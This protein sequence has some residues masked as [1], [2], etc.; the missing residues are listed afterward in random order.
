MVPKWLWDSFRTVVYTCQ[1]IQN[2]VNNRLVGDIMP[3]K[4]MYYFVGA[5]Q[6]RDV[7]NAFLGHLKQLCT[8]RPQDKVLD[9]GCGVGRI[10]LPLTKYLSLEGSYDGIDIVPKG[11]KWCRNNITPRYPNFRFQLADVY[12]GLYNPKGTYKS[13]EYVFPYETSS[14]DLVI[15]T[16]VFTHMFPRDLERYLSEIARVLK[17]GGRCLITYFLMNPEVNA[18]QKQQK[19]DIFFENKFQNY[20]TK[21]V[22]DPEA[23]IAYDEEMIFDL[24]KKYGLTI[25]QP[26]HYGFWSGRAGLDYQDIVIACK[27]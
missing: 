17:S 21:D 20:Y 23:A 22:K 4:R 26:I 24:Y 5:G 2:W 18:Y 12:N 27:Q 9:V 19:S 6:F 15:L 16:S 10:A 14:F 7:G 11:I 25:E 8:L 3:P 1:D 13:E